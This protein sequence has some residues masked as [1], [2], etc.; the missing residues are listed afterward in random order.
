MASTLEFTEGE[1]HPQTY[2]YTLLIHSQ[3]L[4]WSGFIRVDGDAYQLWGAVGTA[5]ELSSIEI[6]PT[7]SVLNVVADSMNVKVTFLSPIEVRTQAVLLYL[8]THCPPA[9]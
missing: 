4:G 3:T 8:V 6:T 5:S 9:R 2:L 1:V 7:R